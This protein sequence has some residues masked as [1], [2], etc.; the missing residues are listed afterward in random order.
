MLIELYQYV[1][2]ADGSILCRFPFL[3]FQFIEQYYSSLL[4]FFRKTIYC[5]TSH[6]FLKFY[7]FIRCLENNTSAIILLNSKLIICQFT[8]SFFQTFLFCLSSFVA[9]A[10][11]LR[12]CFIFRPI[13]RYLVSKYFFLS[14]AVFYQQTT[15][16]PEFF[17]T[18]FQKV[19]VV[20]SFY[21]FYHLNLKFM[22]F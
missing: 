1:Q 5:F 17:L 2:E 11:S 4:P 18:F 19:F 16:L 12:L 9:F 6:F 10:V 8:F 15:Y 20:N 22:Y 14:F 3:L 7:H 13:C 21:N